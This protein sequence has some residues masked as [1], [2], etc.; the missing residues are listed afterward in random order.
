MVEGSLRQQGKLFEINHDILNSIDNLSVDDW[1]V[2]EVS[3]SDTLI[4]IVI[5]PRET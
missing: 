1:L 5:V 3:L 2:K 4:G